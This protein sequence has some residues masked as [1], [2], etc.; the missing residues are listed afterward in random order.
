M[1]K[2]YTCV[3]CGYY[4]FNDVF[5]E[6]EICPICGW[7][8]SFLWMFSPFVKPYP[9]SN[10]LYENYDLNIKKISK[11]EK[12][13][14]WY[15][16]NINNYNYKYWYFPKYKKEEFITKYWLK[17]FKS[18]EKKFNEAQKYNSDSKVHIN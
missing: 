9:N 14:N 15:P 16:I 3:S 2:K 17:Y 10:S 6:F 11:Y 8:D 18:F 13:L 5:S 7:Q 12:K 1:N 4:V